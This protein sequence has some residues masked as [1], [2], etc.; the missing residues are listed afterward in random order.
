MQVSKAAVLKL[1]WPSRKCSEMVEVSQTIGRAKTVL[2]AHSQKAVISA[3]VVRRIDRAAKRRLRFGGA[4]TF[5]DPV[6]RHMRRILLPIVDNIVGQLGLP[7]KCFE[8]SGV[9]LGAASAL[10]VGISISGLSADLPAFIAM[11]SEAL[12]IPVSNDFVATGHIASVAGDISAVKGIPAKVEAAGN[13]ASVKCFIYPN[14]EKDGSLKA[15]SPNRRSLS[16]DAIIAA[17][18]SIRTCAVRD[19]GQ[20]AG[21]VFTEESIIL[22]SLKEGFFGI[23]MIEDHLHNPVM[24]V[25]TFLTSNNQKRFW[26]VLDRHFLQGDC[27]KG[28][29]LL[30]AFVQFYLA[31]QM[32]P[33]GFGARLFQ[34]IRSLPTIARK[35]IDF[36]IIEKRLCSRLHGLAREEKDYDDIPLLIDA[37]YGRNIDETCPFDTQSGIKVSNYE[38]IVFD[39][40]VSQINEQALARKFGAI[41]LARASFR[42]EKSRVKSYAALINIIQEYYIHL[43]RHAGSSPEKPNMSDVRSDA[44]KLLQRTFYDKGG[45]KAAFIQARDCTQ[46]GL[47]SILDMLTE[48]YKA[49]KQDAYINRVFKDAIA[50]MDWE[51]RIRCMRSI[52]KKIGPSLPEELKDQPPERFA[53]DD[54]TIGTII[55]TYV[56]CSDKFNQVLSRM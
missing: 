36:A 24:D 20:L 10:S 11:L 39:T 1:N 53:R 50:D 35:Q 32:Y 41:D 14:L 16:I 17:K 30:D 8:I 47:R 28:K 21:Q 2:V 31:K 55:Q 12:Q 42:L 15:L 13:D 26:D 37:V 6:R 49:E 51:E 27:E 18:K 43:Q 33:R 5:S 54:E 44:I 7:E 3:I 40:V 45:D 4:V 29:K 22:A 56:R 25:V 52:M 19:I 34:L 9:N 38:N 46:G 23:S 48:Q